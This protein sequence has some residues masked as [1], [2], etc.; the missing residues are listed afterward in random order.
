MPSRVFNSASFRS[1]GGGMNG[2]A[3]DM[4]TFIE[5]IR[6]GGAPILSADTAHAM[7]SVQS[8]ALAIPSRGPGWGFGFGG[9]ILVDPAAGKSP[10]SPG[11]YGWG[12]VWGHTWFVDPVKRL[13]V[14]SLS[15][16]AFEGMSGRYPFEL[17]D[18]V[19]ADLG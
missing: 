17:R 3:Q 12:G 11:T 15:N 10:Q 7:M 5:A 13:S 6:L 1:G 9:A 16:T 4:L 2:T 14:V 8:G 18:A 19:Y